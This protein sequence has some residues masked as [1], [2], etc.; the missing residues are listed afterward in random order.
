M[1]NEKISMVDKAFTE[2]Q[3]EVKQLSKGISAESQKGHLV[4]FI[5]VLFNVLLAVSI[6][7]SS[8]EKSERI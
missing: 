6:I 1:N 5:K 2:V 7:A 8:V 4:R 3:K